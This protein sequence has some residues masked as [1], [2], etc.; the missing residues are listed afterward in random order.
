MSNVKFKTTTGRFYRQ[1]LSC[2]VIAYIDIYNG[3]TKTSRVG[4]RIY[5]LIACQAVPCCVISRC[6]LLYDVA[7]SEPGVQ[8]TV[9]L[10]ETQQDRAVPIRNVT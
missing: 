8:A 7:F 4:E 6:T 2:D 1:S 9:Q 10:C 5:Y 3:H